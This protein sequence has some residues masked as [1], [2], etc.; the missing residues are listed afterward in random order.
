MW[1]ARFRLNVRKNR[2]AHKVVQGRNAGRQRLI[3]AAFPVPAEQGL[4]GFRARES[5]SLRGQQGQQPP[6]L[7]PARLLG[8]CDRCQLQSGCV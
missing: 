1:V 6:E 2:F 7:L 4:T 5:P 8:V 3:H